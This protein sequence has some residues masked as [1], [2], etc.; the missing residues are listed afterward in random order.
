[1]TRTS[2][3]T[4]TTRATTGSSRGVRLR[5]VALGGA[6]VVLVGGLTACGASAA[7]DTDPDRRSFDLPG[8][9]LTVDSGDS[10]LEII[11]ADRTPSGKVEVTRWFQGTVALGTDPKATWSLEGDRL[12]L[13]IKCSG[14][15]ANCSAKHRI[16]VP[17]GVA[18]KVEE[19]DGSV[20][21]RG[22]RDA[23]NIRTGDG[24]IHVT[25]TTGPLTLRTG[26]GSVRAEVA[27][28][29]VR[30]RTGDGS[31]RLELSAVPDLVESRSGDGSV[32]VELPRATYRVTSGTGDGA[33]KVS[34]PRDDTSSHVVDVRT[35]DGSLTVRTAN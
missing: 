31:I 8:S 13:R 23:L 4:G 16:E 18:V 17:R 20:R 32:T 5:A 15:V 33:E 12:K 30:A 21:A 28:R 3:T 34:V 9:T 2:S 6:A 11:A 1:M 25:D 35:G 19:G 26:D 29:T 27:S 24:S 7:D 22:F 14:I 10:A